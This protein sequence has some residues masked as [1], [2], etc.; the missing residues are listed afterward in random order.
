MIDNRPENYSN[1]DIGELQ[2]TNKQNSIDNDMKNSRP[3]YVTKDFKDRIDA[4]DSK[5]CFYPQ[6]SS[7]GT[8]KLAKHLSQN[9]V[10]EKN[11][12]ERPLDDRPVRSVKG[13]NFENDCSDSNFPVIL[14]VFTLSEDSIPCIKQKQ[15]HEKFPVTPPC[16]PP[17]PKPVQFT[18][19]RNVNFCDEISTTFTSINS[20]TQFGN[21]STTLK[22]MSNMYNPVG[23][24]QEKLTSGVASP[25]ATNKSIPD[26]ESN[27]CNIYGGSSSLSPREIKVMQ[28]KK[29]LLEQEAAL[30]RLRT[31]RKKNKHL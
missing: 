2:P 21:E 25:V 16:S 26:G 6:S 27:N 12:C 5:Q 18:E 19:S 22:R 31:K 7:N 29:R 30:K 3:F 23:H 4:V 15:M 13:T 11:N 10:Q 1:T 9:F 8:V 24:N 28:L 20:N 14:N 17:L